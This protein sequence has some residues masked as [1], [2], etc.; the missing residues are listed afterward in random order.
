MK[1]LLA[2]IQMIPGIIKAIQAFEEAIPVQ[3]AG[4]EK[5]AAMIEIIKTAYSAGAELAPIIEKTIGILVS[6]FNKLGIFKT[7]SP[8]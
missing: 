8:A 2:I 6:L 1:T 3:G 5:L 7:T 4:K